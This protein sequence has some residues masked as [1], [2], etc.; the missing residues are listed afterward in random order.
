V[1]TE[2]REGQ[3]KME[4]RVMLEAALAPW[5]MRLKRKATLK[6]LQSRK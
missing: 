6:R 1:F 3:S 5:R 4:G 2:R